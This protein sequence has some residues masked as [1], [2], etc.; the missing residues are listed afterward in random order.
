MKSQWA[1]RISAWWLE[2]QKNRDLKPIVEGAVDVA[3]RWRV[4]NEIT[5]DVAKEALSASLELAYI[6]GAH[7]RR[8]FLQWPR[9]SKFL[10]VFRFLL[11]RAER[12]TFDIVL[13]DI[14]EDRSEML[15]SGLHPNTVGRVLLWR[16]F[17][18]MSGLLWSQALKALPRRTPK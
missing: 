9:V 6:M 2:R 16:L 18:E 14:L 5:D 13:D 8:S 3:Y 12:E 10:F 11:P 15:Q 4:L 17:T 1:A 7:R